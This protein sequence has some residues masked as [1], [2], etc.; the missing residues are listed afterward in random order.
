MA[1]LWWRGR[2]SAVPTAIAF[3]VCLNLLLVTKFI[4]PEWLSRTLV[5]LACWIGIAVWLFWVVRSIKELPGL[6]APRQ[7]SDQPDCFPD[8][9]MAFL[10]ES[11]DEAEGL[12]ADVLAIEPR[13]PPALLLLAGVYR[14]T[15]RLEAAESLLSEIRRLEA[16]DLWWLE[17]DAEKQRLDR[18]VERT[19]EVDERAAD[20]EQSADDEPTGDGNE[21]AGADSAELPENQGQASENKANSPG[22][23]HAGR[24]T[25]DLTEPRSTA[26]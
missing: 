18:A 22:A 13:D 3:A 23:G 8:A 21:S 25:A 26:A 15:N 16:A 5:G 10:R 9:Q 6:I 11:W 4:Y 7:V 20:S 19:A 1:E 12:L 14:K 24:E 2:L 17:I